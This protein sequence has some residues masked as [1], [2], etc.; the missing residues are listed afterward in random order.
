M[1]AS[2]SSATRKNKAPAPPLGTYLDSCGTH[3]EFVNR[4]PFG[5]GLYRA[6]APVDATYVQDAEAFT[7]S[8]QRNIFRKQDGP[9]R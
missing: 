1:A 9:Q 5:L 2:M 3:Y 4:P 7:T 8:L 6:A